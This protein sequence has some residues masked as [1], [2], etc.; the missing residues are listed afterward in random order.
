VFQQ[1]TK[2]AGGNQSFSPEGLHIIRISVH[3]LILRVT[4]GRLLFVDLAF[5]VMILWLLLLLSRRAL[6]HGALRD[7][8]LYHKTFL[9][10]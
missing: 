8:Q 7:H 3:L 1:S 6:S 2:P 5:Y 10:L 4:Q 9:L